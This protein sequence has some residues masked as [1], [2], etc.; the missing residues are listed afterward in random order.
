MAGL[1]A[2]L[3]GELGDEGELRSLSG[4]AIRRACTRGNRLGAACVGHLGANSLLDVL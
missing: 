4:E 1:L 3:L 2:G